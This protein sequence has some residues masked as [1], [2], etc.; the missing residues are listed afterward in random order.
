MVLQPPPELHRGNLSNVWFT[1]LPALS[2][3]GSVAYLLAGPPNP[4]TYIAGSFFLVSALAMVIGSLLAA[5]SQN[6]G[7]VAQQRWEFLRHL[8]RTRD[9][10]RRTAQAQRNHELWGGPDPDALWSL[11]ASPRLWERRAGDDDF[12]SVRIGVGPRQLAT[13]LVPSP[14][15]P[16]E[17]LD[18]LSASALRRFITTHRAVPELPLKVLL[19]RFSAIGFSADPD[20]PDAA[21]AL[22][23]ALLC[24][25]AVFHAPADLIIMVCPARPEDPNWAWVK[26][27]PHAQHPTEVD[28]AGPVRLVDPSLQA[29]EDLLGAELTRRSG[30]NPHAAEPATDLPQVLIV[31][32]GAQ[33]A[34]TELALDPEGLAAVTVLDLDGQARE[35]VRQGGVRLE[36][37]ADAGLSV[38]TGA[39]RERLGRADAVAGGRGRGAGPA[40]RRLPAGRRRRRRRGPVRC[41]RDAARAARLP[42]RRRAR[43]GPAVAA[44]PAARPVARADRDRR[45]RR[46]AGA[47]HQGGRPGRH[48]PARAADR[49][50]RVRQVRAAA[51]AGARAGR[52]APA[53]GAEP[54]AGRLQGRRHLRRH[55]PARARG[56][57]DHQPAGRRRSGLAH[58][59]G[60]V[61][62]A[63]PAPGAAARRRRPGVGA[64]L[65]AGP[66]ARRRAGAAA[67]P[68][69]GGRRVL[70]A[71]HPAGVVRRAVR[72]DRPAGPVAGAA[73]AAGQ[74][75]AGRGEDPRPGGAPVLPDRAAHVLPGGEPHRAR[76]PGRLHAA[77]R[78]RARAAQG[79]HRGAHPVPH[80]LRLRRLH[81]GRARRPAGC[82]PG[83]PTCARSRPGCCRSR[84]TVAAAAVRCRA[85]SGGGRPDPA[86]HAQRDGRAD[87]GPRRHRAPG[88]A[89]PAGRP[90]AAGRAARRAGRTPRPR[91]RRRPRHRR[92]CRSRSG[93][94]TC[95]SSSAG[96]R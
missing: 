34:G 85:R 21:R 30:F 11:A 65:R 75:A 58:V 36:I 94:W 46:R 50:D 26:W 40:A 83:P 54:G 51:H 22:V 41:G 31:L 68:G 32:D 91:L 37:D 39:Q 4:I 44:A 9:R 64:R 81:P 95:R 25:A 2:G 76:R 7:E 43:P 57:G 28:F 73:P 60:A 80:H 70:R 69:G 55:V 29:L 79:G 42:G 14:S 78:P 74:P 38:V 86:D 66:P 92:R 88:V 16:V 48:G 35:V 61:R 56:R 12:G 89:A 71:D 84:R 23:R 49:R 47:G 93:T 6:R 87:R 19:R 27:L 13:P 15:G 72:A 53:R 59:R 18:P 10:V 77:Q 90:A 3:L 63:D 52:A 67:Q 33:V 5:R 1:A 62:R 17:D 20:A 96:S 24:Q 82:S 45:R 8:A